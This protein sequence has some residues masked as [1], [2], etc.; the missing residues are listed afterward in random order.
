M[1][2]GDLIDHTTTDDCPCGPRNQI[3]E[4]DDGSIRWL[5]IHHS[6]DAREA[7]E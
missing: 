2:I 7:T 6:L 1:P 5:V 3:V 4:R